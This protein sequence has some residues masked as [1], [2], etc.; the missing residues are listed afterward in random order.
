MA[1]LRERE[2]AR[3][4][5]A[6]QRA[7]N[8]QRV[9]RCGGIVCVL[10]W[11]AMIVSDLVDL[12]SNGPAASTD[13]LISI[14]IGLLVIAG[15]VFG[16]YSRRRRLEQVRQEEAARGPGRAEQQPSPSTRPG[17][18]RDPTIQRFEDALVNANFWKRRVEAAEALAETGDEATLDLIEEVIEFEADDRVRKALW[19][20]YNQIDERL[21]RSV[22]REGRE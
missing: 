1:E 14:V 9:S 5:Q 15:A 18:S 11:V 4:R 7:V 6:Q 17:E 3:R 19:D 2:E 10:F 21:G 13:A 16:L 12:A 22:G 20:S 8:Q